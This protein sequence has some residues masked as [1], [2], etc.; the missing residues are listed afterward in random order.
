MHQH[1]F[2]LPYDAWMGTF[3]PHNADHAEDVDYGGLFD[4][5]SISKGEAE[6]YGSFV[7]AVNSVDIPDGFSLVSTR[8]ESN[9]TGQIVIHCGMY[10]KDSL[11]ASQR[12]PDW[13]FVEVLVLCSLEESATDY[14]DECTRSAIPSDGKIGSA[15]D[16]MTTYASR[17]FEY[18]HRTHLFCVILL[19]R[20]ALLG[21]WDRSGIVSSCKFDYKKEPTK[22]VR[23]F[24]RAARATAEARG[25]DLTATRVVQG[26]ADHELLVA[27]KTK[28]LAKDDYAGKR[29]VKTLKDDWPWWRLRVPDGEYGEGEFLVGEPTFTQ[30]G[31]VGQGTRGYIALCV[32]DPD[33]PLVYL[34]DCWRV[35][36]NRTELEGNILSYLNEKDVANVPTALYHGDVPGQRSISQTFWGR[37]KVVTRAAPVQV[38]AA[39][40]PEEA[41]TGSTQ[42]PAQND[43]VKNCPMK[44]HQHY[45]LVVK[46]VGM[47]L[48][49]FPCGEVLVTV[50]IDA[51]NAHEDA[52]NKAQIMHRDISVGNILMVPYRIGEKTYYQ[53]LLG[54]WELSKR[55]EDMT[56]EARHPGRTFSQGTWQFM[57]VNTLKQPKSHVQIA[58]ELE[59]FLHVMIYCAIRYLPHTCKYVG[60]FLYHYFD[61]G[62]RRADAE[63]EYTC[64]AHKNF[65]V[66][67]GRLQTHSFDPIIFLRHPLETPNADETPDPACNDSSKQ[68]HP[69]PSS[70]FSL[71]TIAS[72]KV[73]VVPPEKRHPINNIFATL[74]GWFGAR[75]HLLEAD[76]DD[77]AP[78]MDSNG[79]KKEIPPIG[80]PAYR[81]YMRNTVLQSSSMFNPPPP[82]DR[83]AELVA[84]ANNLQ[85]HTAMLRF[86]ATETDGGAKDWPG[87]EDKMPDQLDPN[88][89]PNKPEKTKRASPEDEVWA[90]PPSKRLRS[91]A[92]HSGSN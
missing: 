56:K 53:G 14:Y 78:K 77:A 79:Q 24:M 68:E 43:G 11:A 88:Y 22:L 83:K 15:L 42:D 2:A 16:H 1:A 6:M 12:L 33:M 37:T 52:Y 71:T 54:D 23:F 51:I 27:W 10:R 19:G 48:E 87:P 72:K 81:R 8:E 89:N 21:R 84:A 7:D 40:A 28:E 61:D 35:V 39:Q 36:H 38:H 76:A 74:L 5:V 57:S 46:E 26:S 69:G 63:G 91:L 44:T 80:T 9:S 73:S 20:N 66:S 60:D 29:F 67:T 75:Y 58:D 25:H 17:A 86:L 62:T 82:H 32:S 3:L 47:P 70:D 45:R 55:L 85:S 34:K 4:E 65:V 64:G 90:P 18:Q 31:V 59:S 13:A 92:S 49:E 41:M 30:P 50:I